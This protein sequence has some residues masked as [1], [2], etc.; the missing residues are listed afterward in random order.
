M[1]TEHIINSLYD[2]IN[3]KSKKKLR[4]KSIKAICKLIEKI[5]SDKRM[6][7]EVVKSFS[8][9]F[10][11]LRNFGDNELAYVVNLLDEL[12]IVSSKFKNMSIEKDQNILTIE[13]KDLGVFKITVTKEK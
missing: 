6:F 8:S 12:I 11:S 4:K 2:V 3:I 9:F 1:R 13:S 5:L 10:R 7:K